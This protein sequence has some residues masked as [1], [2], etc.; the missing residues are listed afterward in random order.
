M[1]RTFF[2]LS[3]K[4]EHFIIRWHHHC[5]IS[6]LVLY[7]NCF[8]I[9]NSFKKSFPVLLPVFH[10]IKMHLVTMYNTV[11]DTLIRMS[12]VRQPLGHHTQHSDS[13]HRSRMGVL[14]KHPEGASSKFPGFSISEPLGTSGR[15]VSSPLCSNY[16]TMDF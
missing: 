15:N 5:S 13:M 8:P 2:V 7:T 1:S 6:V 10:G 14:P 4:S 3:V 9:L 16:N 11:N 12:A